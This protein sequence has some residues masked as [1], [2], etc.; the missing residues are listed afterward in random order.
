MIR[1]EPS[2]L[3]HI[4]HKNCD[5]FLKSESVFDIKQIEKDMNLSFKYLNTKVFMMS[6]LLTGGEEKVDHELCFKEGCD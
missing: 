3:M 1:F 5:I 4:Y 6:K 2:E